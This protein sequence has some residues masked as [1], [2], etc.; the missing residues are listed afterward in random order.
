MDEDSVDATKPL[1]ELTPEEQEARMMAMMG[2]GGFD[3]TK[4]ILSVTLVNVV[5][6]VLL[7]CEE[8]KALW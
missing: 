3:S 6:F 2:F 8:K 5:F 4:V 1:E 7:V